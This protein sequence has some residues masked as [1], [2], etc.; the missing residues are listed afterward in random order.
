MPDE[1]LCPNCKQV[2]EPGAQFCGNCG[3]TI[4]ATTQSPPVVSSTV[5]PSQ[6]IVSPAQPVVEAQPIVTAPTP[7]PN[8]SPIAQ[9]YQN[10]PMPPQPPQPMQ[11]MMPNNLAPSMPMQSSIPA[12]AIPNSTSNDHR[13]AIGLIMGIIGVVVS[14]LIP[15]I[16]IILGI[17]GIVLASIYK[18][19]SNG[20][21]IAAIILSSLA[22]LVAI[23]T[24][25]YNLNYLKNHS[26]SSLSPN[27]SKSSSSGTTSVNN[28]CYKFAIQGVFNT[29]KDTSL[30]G[31]SDCS[32]DAYNASSFTTSNNVYKFI[33][34]SVPGLTDANFEPI[35]KQAVND[36]AKVNLK[37][38][39]IVSSADTIF[40]TS[41]AY[42]LVAHNSSSNISILEEA[43]FHNT[44]SGN[45]NII[46]IVHAINGSSSVSL[47]DVEKT[48]TWND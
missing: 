44:S 8:P 19:R 33:S 20:L 16:G 3:Q 15:I 4:A 40:S 22:I 17:A 38:Y 30:A 32:V 9:V 12:Y 11:P 29:S 23:G 10:P 25:V 6:A 13:A 37:N 24:F 39:T 26:A 48:W 21:K 43:V 41:K 35:I 28:S 27:S 45:N 46:L 42:T 2:L 18:G 5:E 14:L 31:N 7:A 34:I 1:L 36:D 47:S